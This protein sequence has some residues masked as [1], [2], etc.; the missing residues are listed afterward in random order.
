MT[1]TDNAYKHTLF[2]NAEAYYNEAVELYE[3]GRR[4]DADFYD[5]YFREVFQIIRC[6][7][8]DKEYMGIA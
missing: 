3:A 7:G 8:W 4:D 2:Q 1:N 6:L 5:N